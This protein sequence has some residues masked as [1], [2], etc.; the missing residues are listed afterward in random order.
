MKIVKKEIYTE[1]E[2]NATPEKVWEIL[3]DFTKYSEWNPSVD[4]IAGDLKIGNLV[5]VTIKNGNKNSKMKAKITGFKNNISFS[6]LGKII[7]GIRGEHFFIIKP[8]NDNGIIF[9]QKEIFEGFL[10]SLFQKKLEKDG[11]QNFTEV[12]ITLKKRAES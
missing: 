12:N 7:P 5:T 3:T 10:V 8:N 6:W 9:I 1:I 11:K 4:T 2:I